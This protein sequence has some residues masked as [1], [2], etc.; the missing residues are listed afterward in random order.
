MSE[1][2]THEAAYA[3]LKVHFTD[4]EQVKLTLMIGV[5]NVWNRIGVG[6]RKAPMNVTQ[7]A[8]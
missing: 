1:G 3:D 2:H 4:E 7:A 6:F 8:A 5:I